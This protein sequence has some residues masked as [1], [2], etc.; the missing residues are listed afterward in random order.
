[1]KNIWIY[2]WLGLATTQAA[3]FWVYHKEHASQQLTAE[4]IGPG[5]L[6]LSNETNRL[7]QLAS[8]AIPETVEPGKTS[9][10]DRLV[11]RESLILEL[12]Q[13]QNDLQGKGVETCIV[14]DLEAFLGSVEGSGS[15]AQINAFIS[16]ILD[17][18][19]PHARSLPFSALERLSLF[20][21]N[22]GNLPVLAFELT[23][24]PENMAQSLLWSAGES[25]RWDLLE[26]DLLIAVNS[27]SGW[28]RGSFAF[29]EAMK[30]L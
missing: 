9:R 11:R 14:E 18:I 19:R 15:I 7:I 22:G 13:L 23:G 29:M 25:S 8:T 6:E 28:L 12:H 2:F 27:D 24:S 26:M 10:S 4:A 21:G 16:G 1:M 20:P 3:A 30:P 17:W 5:M